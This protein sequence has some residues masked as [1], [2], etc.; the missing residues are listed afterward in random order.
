MIPK[1]GFF[2]RS[3]KVVL[4]C[5]LN[6][7]LYATEQAPDF[8]GFDTSGAQEAAGIIEAPATIEADNSQPVEPD[9]NFVSDS[10]T[11]PSADHA[12]IDTNLTD[13]SE[14]MDTTTTTTNNSMEQGVTAA[15]DLLG[16]SAAGAT[17]LGM[18]AVM[19]KSL[20]GSGSL[21]EAAKNA[22]AQLIQTPQAAELMNNEDLQGITQ[23]SSLQKVRQRA[24]R[25]QEGYNLLQSQGLPIDGHL[26]ESTAGLLNP[27]NVST[28]VLQK[29][30]SPLGLPKTKMLSPRGSFRRT[31]RHP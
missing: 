5:F 4:L 20:K 22:G 14:N 12:S 9:P 15:K 27:D 18:I 24:T 7:G 21:K 11:P 1:I 31:P 26:T 19:A 8:L 10:A 25:A 30:H 23:G 13:P 16:L 17:S 2:K 28:G 6:L 29:L 3:N